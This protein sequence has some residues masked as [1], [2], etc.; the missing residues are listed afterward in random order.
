MEVVSPQLPSWLWEFCDTLPS[1]ITIRTQSGYRTE[2][3]PP[4]ARDF[5]EHLEGRAVLGLYGE[6]LTRAISIDVDEDTPEE[7]FQMLCEVFRAAGL[8]FYTSRGTSRGWRVWVFPTQVRGLRYLEGLRRFVSVALQTAKVE[9]LPSGEKGSNLPFY[10]G[11]ALYFL[12]ETERPIR[13]VTFVADRVAAERLERVSLALGLLSVAIEKPPREGHHKHDVAWAFCNLARRLGVESE[14]VEAWSTEAADILGWNL[15]KTRERKSVEEWGRELRR[16]LDTKDTGPKWG[17]PKLKEAGY[18]IPTLISDRLAEVEYPEPY[19]IF[20]DQRRPEF[21]LEA[22]GALRPYIEALSQEAGGAV[23]HAYAAVF[24]YMSFLTQ[25]VYNVYTFM[26]VKPTATYMIALA[27]SGSRKSAILDVLTVEMMS[28]AKEVRKLAKKL[29]ESREPEKHNKRGRPPKTQQEKYWNGLGLVMSDPTLEGLAVVLSEGV[30]VS[31]LA[32]GEASSFLGNY[33]FTRERVEKSVGDLCNLWDGIGISSY[34]ADREKIRNAEFRRVTLTLMGTEASILPIWNNRAMQLQGGW[35]RFLFLNLKEGEVT[36][37]TPKP[38]DR[39]RGVIEELLQFGR[40]WVL[41]HIERLISEPIEEW[42]TVAPGHKSW[43]ERYF[44]LLIPTPEALEVATEL[45]A[46]LERQTPHLPEGA[47]RSFR[48]KAAEHA[49]RIAATLHVARY[50]LA[51]KEPPHLIGDDTMRD[52]AEL[53]RFHFAHLQR[54]EGF[55]GLSD[56]QQKAKEL[57]GLLM[58]NKRALEGQ[59]LPV[60]YLTKCYPKLLKTSAATYQ[61]LQELWEN[62]YLLPLNKRA[63]TSQNKWEIPYKSFRLNPRAVELCGVTQKPPKPPLDPMPPRDTP[64]DTPSPTSTH[65]T[66]PDYPEAAVAEVSNSATGELDLFGGAVETKPTIPKAKE[67]TT[68]RSASL[69]VT[70]ETL[71]QMWGGKVV[72]LTEETLTEELIG[73]LRWAERLGLDTETEGLGGPLRLLQ[74]YNPQKH[75]VYLLDVRAWP[76]GLQRLREVLEGDR[77]PLLVAWNWAFDANKLRE[78]GIQVEPLR[79][80]DGMLAEQMLAQQPYPVGLSDVVEG[81]EGKRDLQRSDWGGK[82]SEEQLTYAA[83]DAVAAYAVYLEFRRQT[84]N[85]AKALGVVRVDSAAAVVV[86][87]MRREGFSFAVEE[88]EQLL[89]ELGRRLDALEMELHQMVGG[90]VKWRSTEQVKRVLARF[91][92]SV[93]D[94]RADTLRPFSDQPIVAKLLAYK[95]LEAVRQRLQAFLDAAYKDGRIHADWSVLGAPTGRMACREP[96]LQAV[97]RLAEFRRLFRAPDGFYIVKVDYSQI[98]LRLAAVIAPDAEMLRAFREGIDL[99]KFTA[100][101]VLGKDLS[102]VTKS[103]RQLAKGLNFGLVYGMGAKTL[104]EL[105]RNDYGVSVTLE[106]AETYRQEFFTLY[107]GLARWHKKYRKDGVRRVYT[108]LGR[109]RETQNFTEKL[110]TPVQGSGADG[111]KWAMVSVYRDP[112]WRALGASLVAAVHDELV[113]I[114]PKQHA[115]RALE[116]LSKHMREGM[117]TIVL[118][119]AKSVGLSIPENYIETEGGVYLDWGVTSVTE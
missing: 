97:P 5:T 90:S 35:G 27:P 21:P 48:E 71:D 64:P 53:V 6:S 118:N 34:R 62:N 116:L 66:E 20:I 113:A 100:A 46:E 37:T 52:A 36:T 85:Y 10:G 107:R 70:K 99:H 23:E 38:D 25:L 67:K 104:Q 69:R 77:G 72:W 22:T 50:A 115:W 89:T 7:A 56:T 61:I 93:S 94:I 43:H 73:E 11:R 103:E 110:N 59:S 83:R 79:V 86:S 65:S 9:L 28:V 33:S 2:K 106:E 78:A 58:L 82:L 95:D 31:W 4:D 80:W 92:V 3:R 76:E 8:S 45:R 68:K 60:S 17:I 112:E 54:M 13:A 109:Y 12:G 16:F 91:G 32:T 1:R 30:P 29:A 108:M 114:A 42:G 19:P 47:L 15:I 98:E 96:N 63:V 102:E 75:K 40:T 49:I 105:L 111:L 44:S 88:G 26:S 14:F 119:Y 55:T 81:L 101:K 39:R 74:L 18:T 84:T 87:E 51:G 24:G 57:L 117:V 41:R